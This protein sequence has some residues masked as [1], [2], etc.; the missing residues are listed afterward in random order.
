MNNQR[1]YSR[2]L[3][4]KIAETIAAK[5]VKLDLTNQIYRGETKI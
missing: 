1:K 5:T 2:P 3:S 4:A